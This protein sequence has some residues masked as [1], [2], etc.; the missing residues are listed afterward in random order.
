[1]HKR[2]KIEEAKYFYSK[3]I[4][5][6]EHINYFRYNLSAFLSAARSPLQYAYK[7][8]NPKDKS[9]AKPEAQNWYKKVMEDPLLKFLRDERN[10]NIHDEPVSF[11][12]DIEIAIAEAVGVGESLSAKIKRTDGSVELRENLINTRPKTKNVKA[13]VESKS[14]YR[15]DKWT[16]DEDVLTLC[17][18]YIQELEKVVRDGVSKGFITE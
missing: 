8:V 16:G 18:K 11:R 6:Y 3:M 9:L 14:T 5:N 4:K 12:K 17:E 13:T 7:E 2:E 15:F 1:M 10:D